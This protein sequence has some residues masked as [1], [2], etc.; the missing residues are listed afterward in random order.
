[1]LFMA[2]DIGGTRARIGLFE[3]GKATGLLYK[4]VL[5][6][7]QYGSFQELLMDAKEMLPHGERV[8][9]LV[10]AVAGPVEK[11]KISRPPHIPWAVDIGEAG[12]VFRDIPVFLLNDLEALCY[13]SLW[14][15]Q[16]F[17]EEIHPGREPGEG[18]KLFMGPGT[19]FGQAVLVQWGEGRYKALPSEGGHCLYAFFTKLELEYLSWLVQ[20]SID[21]TL[22]NLVSGRGL[23]LAHEFLYGYPLDPGVISLELHKRPELLSFMARMLGRVARHGILNFMATGGLYFTGGML[24]KNPLFIKSPEFLEELR[25]HGKMGHILRDVAVFL[26]QDDLAGLWGGAYYLLQE[27][28]IQ[29]I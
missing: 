5:L 4:K 19:G 7:A 14:K 21:P 20:R 22:D 1:M 15:G 17:F 29:G 10:L 26:N 12:S 28:G 25:Q 2:G 8:Q 18:P 11:G 13:C 9:G 3:G 24:M 23:S 16:G 6:T 27:L